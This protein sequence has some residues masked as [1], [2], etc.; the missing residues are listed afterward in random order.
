MPHF[1]LISKGVMMSEAT[2]PRRS[3]LVRQ[4]LKRLGPPQSTT[5]RPSAVKPRL[6]SVVTDECQ[7]DV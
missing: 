5:A 7:G 3:R 4:V 2:K 6:S 1:I